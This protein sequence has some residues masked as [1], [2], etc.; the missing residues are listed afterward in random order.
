[1]CLP[2]PLEA[3]PSIVGR[4]LPSTLVCGIGKDDGSMGEA[5]TGA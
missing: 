4:R 3:T 5:T 2:R 1:M